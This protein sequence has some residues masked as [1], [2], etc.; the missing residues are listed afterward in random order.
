M[1]PPVEKLFVGLVTDAELVLSVI[2][3]GDH[4]LFLPNKPPKEFDPEIEPE[5]ELFVILPPLN[6]V[7]ANHPIW[8]KAPNISALE[9]QL[10]ID[11]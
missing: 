10:L 1:K 4:P 8:S 7:P 5:A 6:I 11:S 2:I 3:K 9:W